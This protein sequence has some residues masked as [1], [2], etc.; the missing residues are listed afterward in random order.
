[1]PNLLCRV[2]EH[3]KALGAVLSAGLARGHRGSPAAAL[4]VHQL[5]CTPVL[6]SGLETLVLNKAEIRIID[7]HYQYTIQNLQRLHK[8]TPR[9]IIFFL[10]GSLPGEAHLH[11]RQLSLFSMICHLSEDPLHQ[12]AKFALSTLPPSSLSWF[13]QVRDICLQYS[14]PHPLV[15]LE[16][17]IAKNRFKNLVKHHVTDYWQ[18]VLATEC[19]SPS[20][21]SLRYFDPYSASLQHPHPMWTST[22][23]NSFECCKSTV[24]A[25]MLSGRYRTEMM[26]RFWSTNRSGHCLSD[27]CQRVSGDLEHL[28]TVCPALEHIRHRLH[29]LWCL[30]TVDCPPL[31]SLILRILGSSHETQVRFILDSTAC[32][33]LI[34]LMEIFGQEIQDRVLYLTRTWAFAIHR[35]KMKLLGRWPENVKTKKTTANPHHDPNPNNAHDTRHNCNTDCDFHD[36]SDNGYFDNNITSSVISNNTSANNFIFPGNTTPAPG[37]T[38]THPASTTTVGY[39]VRLFVPDDTAI[40]QHHE[41]PQPAV[42]LPACITTIT[43]S[44]SANSVEEL[45]M[46]GPGYGGS[47]VVMGGLP[48]SGAGYQQPDSTFQSFLLSYQLSEQCSQYQDGSLSMNVVSA[49]QQPYH[50]HHSHHIGTQ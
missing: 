39:D 15:L 8:K 12:H 13:H 18:Q 3:K 50:S 7:K 16:K 10:A 11:M 20:L 4:R 21:S 47:R 28:L 19:T 45:D 48:N 42:P 35:N 1:M 31:H 22:A 49:P 5:H 2:S 26:C 41:E 36:V 46:I 29:S 40:V 25:R 30:K 27:T 37:S 24:L 43:P 44:L 6:F 32:P 23:G 34:S 17:P 38:T 9:S 14:L 33:E